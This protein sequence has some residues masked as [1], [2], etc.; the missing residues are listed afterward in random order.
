M[1]VQVTSELNAKVWLQIGMLNNEYKYAA[2]WYLRLT[3]L[4]R[5][6]SK[7]YE[8]VEQKISKAVMVKVNQGYRIYIITQFF[9]STVTSNF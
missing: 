4:C 7:H 2:I 3:E 9:F 5:R 8:F 1:L 6:A